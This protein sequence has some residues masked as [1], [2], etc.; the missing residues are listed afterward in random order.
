M[1]REVFPESKIGLPKRTT[2]PRPPDRPFTP[3]LFLGFHPLKITD[4]R[5]MV[6]FIQQPLKAYLGS[7]MHQILLGIMIKALVVLL[8]CRVD[9]SD[10]EADET[11]FF[12]LILYYGRGTAGGEAAEYIVRLRR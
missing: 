6:G 9:A 5:L 8:V 7:R 12:H 3:D 11:D 4:D 2:R 1:V 10:D